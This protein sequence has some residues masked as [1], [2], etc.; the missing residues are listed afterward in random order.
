QPKSQVPKVFVLKYADP[1]SVVRIL[2]VFGVPMSF[3]SSLHTLA[4]SATPDVMP[5]IEEAIKR[6][7]VPTA[8]PQNI[9]LTVYYLIGGEAENTPGGPVPKELDSV[10]TQLKNSFAFKTYR[11]M[12]TLALRTR[13]GQSADTSSSP[14]PVGPGLPSLVDQLHIRS[15]NLAADG[16]TVSVSNLKAGMRLPTLSATFQPGVGG[17]GGVSPLNQQFTYTDL[18]LSADVDIKEGQKVVVG[19]LSVNKDQALFLV[20][21]A[22]IV[23]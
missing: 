1:Q 16:S 23:N 2:N 17:G 9:E 3:D 11:L 22:H 20:L 5:A 19:R 21:T 14:G 8:A 7:D 13:T 6:L 15:A 4:V 12:D 18:G 10:V